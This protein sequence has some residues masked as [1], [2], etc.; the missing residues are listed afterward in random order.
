[1]TVLHGLAVMQFVCCTLLYGAF[2]RPT[3]HKKKKNAE[4]DTLTKSI[5]SIISDENHI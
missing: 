3:K 1:M 2:K 4:I 5:I